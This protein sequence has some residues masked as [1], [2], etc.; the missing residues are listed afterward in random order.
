MTI[1]HYECRGASVVKSLG[2]EV[3]GLGILLVNGSFII[4]RYRFLG[5]CVLT[6][7]RTR[8]RL[9]RETV[10]ILRVCDNAPRPPFV[11]PSLSLSLTRI[12]VIT[13]L[14]NFHGENDVRSSD[15]AE[16]K[17]SFGLALAIRGKLLNNARFPGLYAAWMR[18]FWIIERGKS[19]T[20]WEH[21]P[22]IIRLC[23][24]LAS[25]SEKIANC[26]RHVWD[27]SLVRSVYLISS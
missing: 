5:K 4:S 21:L 9:V 18:L 6:T 27:I 1:A 22:G 24:G 23:K 2:N 11:L 17:R 16:S 26:G 25:N 19:V 14:H 20:R 8:P 10:R 3:A 7:I 15:W 12:R 13:P